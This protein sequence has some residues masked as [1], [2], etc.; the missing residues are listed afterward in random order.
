MEK[1][2]ENLKKVH[3]QDVNCI[4]VL[5]ERIQELEDQ[6]QNQKLNELESEREK[7]EKQIADERYRIF[8]NT[9]RKPLE[10]EETEEPKATRSLDELLLED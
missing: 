6:L 9:V 3:Q 2:L 1:E 8:M 7:V 5:E 10:N 4:M